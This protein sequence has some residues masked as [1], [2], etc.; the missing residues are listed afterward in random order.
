MHAVGLLRLNSDVFWFR[1]GASLMAGLFE[2]L[3]RLGVAASASKWGGVFYHVVCRRIDTVL[4]P[5]TKGRL[6]MGPP[7]QTVLITTK[8]AKSGKSRKAS[9]AF[10]WKGDDLIVI[11]SKGGAPHHPAWYHNLMADPRLVTQTRAGVETGSLAKRSAKSATSFL[12][13]WARRIRIL[14]PIKSVQGIG[15]FPSSFFR[16][17]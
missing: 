3:N 17:Y 8:G 14:R 15:R 11:A 6:S 9:L 2:G 13:R 7:G 4:I 12:N 10:M 16:P 5:L 1:R